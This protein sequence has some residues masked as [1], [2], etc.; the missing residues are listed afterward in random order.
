MVPEISRQGYTYLAPFL[1]RQAW[2]LRSGDIEQ[3]RFV[4][5]AVLSDGDEPRFLT[6]VEVRSTG[7]THRYVVPLTIVAGATAE[8]IA[9]DRPE[10][11]VATIAGA[12]RGVMYG[13]ID[14]GT[15]SS[16]FRAIETGSP[17][18]LRQG[19]L[20]PTQ[21]PAFAAIRQGA[22]EPDLAP[23]MPAI[24]RANTT[25]RLGERFWLKV[26][27]RI[28]PGIH[29]E[30]ELDQF[31]SEQMQ[32]PRVPRLA[33]SLD[34][35]P[36]TTLLS[37][38]NPAGTAPS[39][40]AILSAFMSHQMDAWRQA[41]GELKRYLETATAWPPEDAVL[42]ADLDLWRTAPP[43]RAR[44]TI[45]HYLESAGAIGRRTGEMHL[46]LASEPAR[47]RFGA[48][49]LDEA[50]RDRIVSDV[51]TQAGA[52]LAGLEPVAADDRASAGALARRL[53]AS[54]DALT[55]RVHR[56]ASAVPTGPLL[57]RIH[58]AYHLE[59]LLLAEADYLIV[60]FEGDSDRPFD[61]RR[62]LTS[63]LADVVGMIRSFHYAAGVGLMTRAATVPQDRERLGPWARWW[64]T[65]VSASFL[66]SYIAATAGAAFMPHPGTEARALL[67]LLLLE[68]MLA[69]ARDE[70]THRPDYLWIPLEGL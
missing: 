12:R 59:Q 42:P 22:S 48:A 38:A 3:A 67:D 49:T 25:T 46:L 16:M 51:L 19:Q 61:E 13:A 50:E 55:E 37:A 43:E 24:D 28:Q 26:L 9:R 32:Y 66:Q 56:L 65:W 52:A 21:E 62:R 8:E 45:G 1:R 58:G 14:A 60:D 39:T 23:A 64:Q 15:M 40:I 36:A 4:D 69:E 10:S 68:R 35:E 47:Q 7:G 54:R 63:P 57:T 2:F 41:L 17:I 31:L 11:V 18:A 27:R 53:I 6:I 33:G 5:W 44:V 34:Y 30:V 70:A 20:R 29:P